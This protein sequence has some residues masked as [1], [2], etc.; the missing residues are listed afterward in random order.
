MYARATLAQLH[1]GQV[2]ELVQF[3]RDNV[4]PAAQAQ[5]GF[6][7]LLLLTDEHTNKGIA[8]A[9]WETEAAMAASEASDGYYTVQLARGA[10]FFAA[11]P[12]RET[13]QLTLQV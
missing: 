9:L 12:V 13:Y 8:I 2:D 5:Q 11:P 4:V 6:K 7:G 10:H 1:P 3:L